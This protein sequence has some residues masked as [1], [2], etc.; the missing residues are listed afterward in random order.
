KANAAFDTT[1]ALTGPAGAAF[2]AAK[3]VISALGMQKWKTKD[4]G[5]RMNIQGQDLDL[6]LWVR[7]QKKNWGKKSRR[8]LHKDIEGSDKNLAPFKAHFAQATKLLDGIGDGLVDELATFRRHISG[9]FTNESEAWFSDQLDDVAGEMIRYG[10]SH[11]DIAGVDTDFGDI[12][13]RS[14]DDTISSVFAGTF[15]EGSYW[16]LRRSQNSKK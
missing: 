16:L 5:Y 12:M 13:S 6:G 1:V 2:V 10:V 15:N 9:E 11:M 3:Q 7:Q 14:V 4:T 8:I